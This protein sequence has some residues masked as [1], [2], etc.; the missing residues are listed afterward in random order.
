MEAR[1]SI[2]VQSSRMFKPKV[3]E[4]S[5]PGVEGAFR[6]LE[7]ADASPGNMDGEDA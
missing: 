2:G 7:D 4:M 3:S 6:R 5:L 1:R